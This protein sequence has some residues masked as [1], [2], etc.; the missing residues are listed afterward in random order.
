MRQLAPA[1]GCTTAKYDIA[2]MANAGA[3]ALKSLFG[4]NSESRSNKSY[5]PKL[6][7]LTIMATT[8]AHIWP[9]KTFL[10]LPRGM[11]GAAYR[12]THSAPYDPK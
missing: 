6:I 7:R 11:W 4:M 12:R 8:L 5:R 9:K 2:E 3:R 1:G 10:S